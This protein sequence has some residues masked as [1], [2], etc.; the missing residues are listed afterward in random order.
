[1][2]AMNDWLAIAFEMSPSERAALAHQLLLSLEEDGFDEDSEAAWAAE[3]ES[4]L[5][6]IERGEFQA[7]DWREAIARMRQSLARKSS[8]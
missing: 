4:R 8:P 6:R 1:M 7:S 2:S 3:L 5:T